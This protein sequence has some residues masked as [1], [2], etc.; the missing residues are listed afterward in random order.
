MCVVHKGS[1][2]SL[3]LQPCIVVHAKPN[4]HVWG[5]VSCSTAAVCSLWLRTQK[6]RVPTPAAP[7]EFGVLR[8]PIA[9]CFLFRSA[10]PEALDLR[11][12]SLAVRDHTLNSLTDRAV[13]GRG[14]VYRN[15][16]ST[17][18]R[19]SRRS[20]PS[21]NDETQAQDGSCLSTSSPEKK[22]PVIHK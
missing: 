4:P 19:Q 11:F 15:V 8:S 21:V 12:A 6:S 7:Q 2:S 16:V 1:S 18:H 14:G 20:L 22:E 10:E 13:P 5:G 17:C 9:D 3:E